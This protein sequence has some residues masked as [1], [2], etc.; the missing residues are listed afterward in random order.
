LLGVCT[1]TYADKGNLELGVPKGAIWALVGSLSYSVYLVLL[2]RSVES[3]DQ[4]D[5]PMFFV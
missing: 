1:V 4:L 3:E 5:I 2:R